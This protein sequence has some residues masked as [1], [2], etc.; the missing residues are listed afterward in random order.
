MDEKSFFFL[1]VLLYFFPDK[2][3]AQGE[4]RVEPVITPSKYNYTTNF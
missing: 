4:G 3:V 1:F 2:L